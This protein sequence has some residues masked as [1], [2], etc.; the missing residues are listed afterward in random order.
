MQ[1]H[2]NG[3]DLDSHLANAQRIEDARLQQVHERL[4]SVSRSL[5]ELRARREA[6]R[7]AGA[8]ARSREAARNSIEMANAKLV[9][10]QAELDGLRIAMRNRAMIEQ[11]KGMLMVR[12]QIDES[13]AFDYL[14][15]LSN[16]TNRK[17]ADVAADVVRTR[18][19]ETG[20]R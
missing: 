11:A 7:Q 5:E 13:K 12:L 20:L 2:E 6:A 1:V 3:N 16:Q 9:E 8:A 10:I 18:A 4:D 15:S 17:L 14:R 19:G